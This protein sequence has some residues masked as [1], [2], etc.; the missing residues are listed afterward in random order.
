M[1]QEQPHDHHLHHQHAH[2][3]QHGQSHQR[4]QLVRIVVVAALA[5]TLA[6][7]PDVEALPLGHIQHGLLYYLAVYLIIGY[8]ILKESARGIIRGEVFD[9]NFLMVIATVGAF[10][11][12]LYEQS[13][14]YMEAIA[15]MLFFQIGEFF[16]SYAI[17]RSR[18]AIAQLADPTAPTDDALPNTKHHDF[19]NRFAH[20]YTPVVCCGAIALALLPPAVALLTGDAAQWSE[21]LYRALTF[22]VVSCPCALVISIPLTFSAGIDGASREGI[23]FKDALTLEKLAKS[24][25][26]DAGI[27][28][29]VAAADVDHRSNA[30]LADADVVLTDADPHTVT[31]AQRIA[32]RTLRIVWQNIAM[33]IGVKVLCLV[34][35]AFGIAN[36][37]LAT[38]AD[39]GI[40]IIAVLNALRAMRWKGE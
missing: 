12:A 16:Q 40:M 17:A 13:G 11:L 30:T 23:L 18:R 22:I 5:V 20:Y 10:C 19:I 33:A 8:D 14:D 3:H 39:E 34:L 9:E 29:A 7:L 31:K 37:W 35:G 25:P 4:L 24:R 1:R 32:Q 38:F 2:S 26:D 21:W 27:T 36:I 15:V 28:I 6:V